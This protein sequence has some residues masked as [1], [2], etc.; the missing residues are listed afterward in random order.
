MVELTLGQQFDLPLVKDLI[1]QN[2]KLRTQVNL[3]TKIPDSKIKNVDIPYTIKNKLLMQEGEFNGVY[4]P[5]EEIK[6]KIEDMNNKPLMLDHRDT[7]NQGASAYVGEIQNVKWQIGDQGEGAYGDLVVV[8]KPVAQKLAFGA[9]WGVSPTID[10][11]RNEVNGKTIG[12]DLLWKSFSF[13]IQP[14]VRGTMLNAK[15]V[16]TMPEDKDKKKKYPYKYPEK[17]KGEMEIEVEEDVKAILEKKD[18]ELKELREFKDSILKERKAELVNQLLAN[19]YLIGRLEEDELTDRQKHLMEKSDEVLQEI[20]SVIGD[21]SELQS[22]RQFIKD[23]MKKHKGTSIKEAAKA[24]KKVKPK[25][26]KGKGKLQEPEE[27]G[28]KDKPTTEETQPLT[29]PG[30]GSVERESSELK[31]DNPTTK[32]DRELYTLLAKDVPGALN[33]K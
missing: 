1:E 32:A 11:E 20:S 26:D 23:Y 25:E 33:L 14:A 27:E 10:F 8:D 17:D 21:H 16:D 13:V 29:S 28:D 7:Q 18:V 3:T 15:E 4:Y 9:K 2:D 24:W 19:E 30:E 31:D 6:A 22:Y 12:T 5:K